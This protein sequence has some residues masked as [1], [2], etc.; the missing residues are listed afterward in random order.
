MSI[1]TYG[2]LKAAVTSWLNRS[3]LS[4]SVPDFIALAETR[5]A[6]GSKEANL[7]SEP[8]RIR[9]M[10]TSTDITISAQA[11]SLPSG[12]LQPRRLYISST[13]NIEVDYLT[14]ASF[15]DNWISSDSGIPTKYTVEGEQFIFGPSPDT[16]YT[17]KSLYYKKFDAL[18]ADGDTNWLLT[19][20]SG[21]YLFG[22]LI[23]A[24]SFTRNLEQ[25]QY[26]YNKF[27]GIIN[28]LN[29]S[30]KADRYPGPWTATSDTG[31]P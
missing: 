15:W 17:G 21:A 24:F 1:A 18:S 13:P 5:I 4:S 11:A 25:A 27:V 28:G 26:A 29:G 6:Y 23:E 31:N 7:Q 9:A 30:D 22:T 8:L 10:E 12:F 20:A 2:D 14:P 19:N 16:S 3:N